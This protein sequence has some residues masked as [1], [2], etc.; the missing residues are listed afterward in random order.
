ML[1]HVVV[2]FGCAFK[3]PSDFN[4]SERG[5]VADRAASARPSMNRTTA[6]SL[7]GTTRLATPRAAERPGEIDEIDKISSSAKPKYPKWNQWST[8]AEPA[9][10]ALKPKET[11]ALATRISRD[12]TVTAAFTSA[13]PPWLPVGRSSIQWHSMCISRCVSLFNFMQHQTTSDLHPASNG[14]KCKFWNML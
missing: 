2:Q 5:T 10:A 1:S 7:P 8:V 13:T 3:V 4:G 6:V 14:I 12:T 9:S 11:P